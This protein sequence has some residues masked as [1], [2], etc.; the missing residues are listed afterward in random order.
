MFDRFALR[1]QRY[2]I[3]YVDFEDDD[4]PRTPKESANL[5]KKI[6]AD[7]GFP[8]ED[9]VPPT[10]A[11]TTTTTTTTT[12]ADP[13]TEDSHAVKLGPSGSPILFGALGIILSSIIARF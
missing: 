10:L 3:H 1:R 8:D 7:R 6:I 2:G 9:Y 13:T 5:L 4:R 12:T 11:P